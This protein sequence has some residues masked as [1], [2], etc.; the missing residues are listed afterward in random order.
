[1][2]SMISI[3]V[4]ALAVGL[5]AQRAIAQ[6]F[7][8]LARFDRLRSARFRSAIG[9]TADMDGHAALAARVENDP[10]AVMVGADFCSA[11][12]HSVRRLFLL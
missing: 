5:P 8:A 10:K 12:P 9:A 1:M 6:R 2:L 4:T 3:P 11:I 7:S